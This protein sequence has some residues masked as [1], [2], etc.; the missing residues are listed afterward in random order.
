PK[1]SQANKHIAIVIFGGL[2]DVLL[3]SPVIQALRTYWPEA[4]ITLIT[5]KRSQS[6]AQLLPVNDIK[7]LANRD[8]LALF[9]GLIKTFLQI[10]PAIVMASGRS[11]FVSLAMKLAGI[12]VRVGYLASGGWLNRLQRQWLTHPAKLKPAIYASEMHWE[13]IKALLGDHVPEPVLPLRPVVDAATLKLPVDKFQALWPS[14]TSSRVLIHPGASRLSVQTGALKQ[15]PVAHWVDYIERLLTQT[16]PAIS[17]GLCGGPDD[18]E[19]LRQIEASLSAQAKEKVIQFM[20]KTAS[21]LDLAAL[22]QSADVMVCVDS[23]PMHLAVALNKPLVAMF[24]PTNPDVLLPKDNHRFKAVFRSDLDCRPCL[25]TVRKQVCDEP[26]CLSVPPQA[27][28]DATLA[29][30]AEHVLEPLL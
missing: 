8:R 20:G 6:S 12:P 3:A 9:L 16:N 27:M 25:W 24:G 10:K 14:E 22:I 18:A 2:G 11:P 1:S 21:I 13:L 4:D 23:A 28:I 5:E 7:T 26:T 19:V 29:L 30:L 15:W 17:V